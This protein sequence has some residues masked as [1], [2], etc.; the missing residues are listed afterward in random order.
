MGW[1]WEGGH[2]P[3][4]RGK[5]AWTVGTVKA[6]MFDLGAAS[7]TREDAGGEGGASG[8]GAAPESLNA[9]IA[10]D[11]IDLDNILTEGK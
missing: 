7:G 6:N 11:I 2:K 9:R 5:D 1:R 8:R 10:R 4:V 3:A